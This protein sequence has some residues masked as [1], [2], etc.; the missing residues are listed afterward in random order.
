MTI[1]TYKCPSTYRHLLGSMGEILIVLANVLM[2]Q[3]LSFWHV[4]LQTFHH[5]LS[6]SDSAPSSS[7]SFQC[8]LSTHLG[9]GSQQAVVNSM[10]DEF[11]IKLLKYCIQVNLVC[12]HQEFV[13]FWYFSLVHVYQMFLFHDQWQH[14]AFDHEVSS[15]LSSMNNSKLYSDGFRSTIKLHHEITLLCPHKALLYTFMIIQIQA[16]TD[17]N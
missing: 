2:I 13:P 11:V 3:L 4:S 6:G 10:E 12:M 7:V 17:Y 14:Q 16:F 8:S 1:N 5:T 15:D 9:V